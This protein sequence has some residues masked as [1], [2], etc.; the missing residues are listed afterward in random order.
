MAGLTTVVN[1]KAYLGVTGSADD[2][3]IENLIDRVTEFVQRY[4]NRKFIRST[5]DEYYDG[6][7]TVYL[8]LSSYPIVSVELL[9]IDAI[10]KASADYAIY[11]DAGMIRLKDGKFS[12]GVL[13]VHVTYTAGYASIPKDLEQACTEIVAMK[14]YNRGTEK[15]GVT[16][17]NFGEGGAVSYASTL[18]SEI[19]DVLDLF[20]RRSV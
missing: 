2:S 11:A 4:C 3:L 13:N 14:Y 10:A 19:K 20:K 9:E 16:V 1:V 8:F 17:R 6:N 5:Y 7:G 18:P 12:E 15:F